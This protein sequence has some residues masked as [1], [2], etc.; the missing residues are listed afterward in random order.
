MTFASNGAGSSSWSCAPA[1]ASSAPGTTPTNSQ[2]IDQT[3]QVFGKVGAQ[4]ST[5]TVSNSTTGAITD[6]FNGGGTTSFA[7]GGFRTS[8][9][10]IDNAQ[11]ADDKSEKKSDP[12]ASFNALG[13][14]KAPYTKAPPVVRSPWHLW[15]EGRFTGFIDRGATNFDGWHNNATAGA[16]YLFTDRFLLGA[17]V[18]YENFRYGFNNPAAVTSQRGDGF[19]G[20]G[21]FGWKFYDRMRLDGMITYGRL[22]YDTAAGA[23]TGSFGADRLT[24]MG[25]LSGRY[26]M[27]TFYVEPSASV[28]IASEKQDAFTDSAAVAH[29]ALNFTVGRASTGATVG[30]PI[31]WGNIIVTPSF[32]AFGDYRFGDQTVSAASVVPTFGNGWSA[33]VTGGLS[34]A[35]PGNITASATGEY[36]GLGDQIQYWRAT[37]NL[38]VRF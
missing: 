2:I 8:F 9:A 30:T 21:Y 27:G 12:F 10:A 28:T 32:G 17:L 19:S 20:G 24:G 5:I 18:A 14:G 15:V 11:N 6:A 22:N 13:Y 7:A 1:A 25:K 23:T 26:G 36:G 37:A 31:A 4:A 33:H 29:N 38:G 3:R 34:F 35:M 16:S